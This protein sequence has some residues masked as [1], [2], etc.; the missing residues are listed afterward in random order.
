MLF[1]YLPA[2]ADTNPVE[3]EGGIPDE[4][5][6]AGTSQTGTLSP[7]THGLMNEIRRHGPNRSTFELFQ[8]TSPGAAAPGRRAD[9]EHGDTDRGVAHPEPRVPGPLRP[10]HATRCL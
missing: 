2:P 6:V 8:A 5:A 9:R 7:F 10:V 4:T 1:A 3:C